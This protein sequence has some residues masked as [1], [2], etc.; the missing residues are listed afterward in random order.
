MPFGW[1]PRNCIGLRYA[2]FE[3]K[4]ALIEILSSWPR[5]SSKDTNIGV[6]LIVLCYAG[7]STADSWN[8]FFSKGGSTYQDHTQRYLTI[9]TA[10]THCVCERIIKTHST[11]NF[12]QHIFQHY[13]RIV[14]SYY[15]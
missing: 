5:H 12:W 6:L 2:L 8:S 1:G 13:T 10:F 3:L 7:Q 14:G 11:I 15:D 4:F 9:F